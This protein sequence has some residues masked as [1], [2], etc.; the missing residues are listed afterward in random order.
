M[1][2]FE[3]RNSACAVSKLYCVKR[4]DRSRPSS[5]LEGDGRRVLAA[6]TFSLDALFASENPVAF[7]R[8][9][10]ASGA[11]HPSAQGLP[12][13]RAPMLGENTLGG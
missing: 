3:M 10:L 8:A 1:P 5:M 11:P 2:P 6:M 7:A 12:V 4:G 13:L 9:A